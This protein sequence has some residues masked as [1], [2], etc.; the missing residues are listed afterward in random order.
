MKNSG[1][2]NFLRTNIIPAFLA[3]TISIAII[4]ETVTAQSLEA[5]TN[6]LNVT[7]TVA[8]A[9]KGQT[10]LVSPNEE[11]TYKIDINITP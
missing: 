2:G 8:G 9:L 3:L 4:T 6:P 10:G 1:K 11:I 7:K 5:S